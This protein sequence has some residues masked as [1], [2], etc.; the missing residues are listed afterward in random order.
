MAQFLSDVWYLWG[1]AFVLVYETVRAL[2]LVLASP[3]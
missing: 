1:M 3:A 2:P